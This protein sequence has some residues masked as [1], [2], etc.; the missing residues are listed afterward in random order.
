MVI[1]VDKLTKYFGDQVAV[2]GVSFGVRKGEIVGFLGPN[3]AGKTTTMRM[4]TGYLSPTAGS[5]RVLD[6]DVFTDRIDAARHIGYLPENCPL[7][8]DMTPV[9]MLNFFGAARGMASGRLKERKEEVIRVCG[10][11]SVLGKRI[12]KLSRGFRQRVALANALLHEPELLI[13][14]EPTNGLDPNQIRGVRDT[15]R[16]IGQEKTILFSTHVLQ[17][18]AAIA[19]RVI[20][21]SE[22]K[23]VFDDTPE[24]LA[25]RGG[26]DGMEGAFYALTRSG[27][28]R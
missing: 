20:V 15:L 10:L 21:I 1:Q 14:D 27:T 13:L 23:I 25:R 6:L 18:V 22:G 8:D 2:D 26:D 16:Q 7:Y 5:A 12:H 19:T 28:E 24:V 4:L 11:G 17:E 9:D 3:G